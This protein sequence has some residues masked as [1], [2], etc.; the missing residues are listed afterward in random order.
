MGNLGSQMEKSTR[1]FDKCVENWVEKS[2]L[3]IKLEVTDT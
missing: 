3:K 1:L 2:G